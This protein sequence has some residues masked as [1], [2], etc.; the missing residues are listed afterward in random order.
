MKNVSP[1]YWKEYSLLD[2]GNGVKVERF[3]NKISIRP[4]TDARKSLDKPLTYWKEKADTQYIDKPENKWANEFSDWV[5]NYNSKSISV[6]T[7]LFLGNSKHI[8]I[9]PEQAVNWE[10]IAK[11]LRKEDAF[12]NLFGY[13]GVASVVAAQKC[14]QVTHVDSSPSIIKRAKYNAEINQINNIRFINDDALLFCKKELKRGNKYKGIILDP[15]VFGFGAKGKSWK[16]T[17]NISELL[18]TVKQICEKD[19]FIILNTYSPQFKQNDALKLLHEIFGGKAEISF[20]KLS[21]E[22]GKNELLLNDYFI[23]RS[24]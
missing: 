4:E 20:G 10:Y 16:L 22:S 5:I 3:A 15:P 19:S 24:K 1:K 21:L 12:L 6:K 23:I 13:T 18:K 8:G 2:Y 7:K 11:N 14:K 17:K 9:F